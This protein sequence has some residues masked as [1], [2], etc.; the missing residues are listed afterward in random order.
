MKS[1]MHDKWVVWHNNHTKGAILNLLKNPIF[2]TI[3]HLELFFDIKFGKHTNRMEKLATLNEF[4]QFLESNIDLYRG[5]RDEYIPAY[6]GKSFVSFTTSLNRLSTF[7]EYDGSYASSAYM[8]DK[9]KHYWQVKLN[10]KVKDILLYLDV[11]DCEAIVTVKDAL[12]AKLI[13]QT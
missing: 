6:K 3:S 4:E 1:Y 8:L 2:K 9:N 11:M 7:S 5:G 13:K 12:K 10:I